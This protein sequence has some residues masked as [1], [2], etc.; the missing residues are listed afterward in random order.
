MRAMRRVDDRLAFLDV[1][2][3]QRT[4]RGASAALQSAAPWDG[5]DVDRLTLGS[6][7]C[8]HPRDSSSDTLAIL[9]DIAPSIASFTTGQAVW[10]PLHGIAMDTTGP[11]AP[12]TTRLG[13]PGGR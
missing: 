10:R 11:A 8:A 12:L 2:R 4:V 7:G 5:E 1:T 3:D 6:A 9:N 13:S